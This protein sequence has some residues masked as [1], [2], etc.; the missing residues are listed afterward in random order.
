MLTNRLLKGKYDCVSCF[1]KFVYSVPDPFEPRKS[2]LLN[3]DGQK[4]FSVNVITITYTLRDPIISQV[5]L[6]AL[7][8]L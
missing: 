6:S 5:V 7:F 2:F 1:G 4:T 8:I 3:T